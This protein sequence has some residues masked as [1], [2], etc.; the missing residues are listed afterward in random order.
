MRGTSWSSKIRHNRIFITIVTSLAVA[1][2]VGLVNPMPA[3]AGALPIIKDPIRHYPVAVSSYGEAVISDRFG[4]DIDDMMSEYYN[5][6]RKPV[7]V[8]ATVDAIIDAE[9]GVLSVDSSGRV[10]VDPFMTD[11]AMNVGDLSGRQLNQPIVAI[12]PTPNGNGYWMAAADGGVFTF[13]D[14]RFFGSMG[15]AKLNAPVVDI[16]STISGNGYWLLAADGGVFTFGD[17]PFFGS[18]A[19]QIEN[20]Q[21]VAIAPTL[22]GNGYWVATGEGGSFGFVRNYGDAIK[23]AIPQFGGADQYVVDITASPAGNGYWV[24]YD[25]GYVY[26][27]TAEAVSPESLPDLSRGDYVALGTVTINLAELFAPPTVICDPEG[28]G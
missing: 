2:S 22:T 25:G 26:R 18:A 15:G 11:P 6:K 16:K 17:A 3:S 13:G 20:S 24:L 8:P 23:G 9:R 27:Y 5:V 28:C 12:T 4:Q 14:A 21:A 19:S 10:W 1:L 7:S